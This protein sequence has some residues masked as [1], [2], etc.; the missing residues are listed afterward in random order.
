MPLPTVEI[1]GHIV[2]LRYTEFARIYTSRFNVVGLTGTMI[3]GDPQLRSAYND[4]STISW[5]VKAAGSYSIVAFSIAPNKMT[6]MRTK[7]V[8]DIVIN[9]DIE[10]TGASNVELFPDFTINLIT[11]SRKEMIDEAA[12]KLLVASAQLNAAVA[13]LNSMN[14]TKEEVL[15]AFSRAELKSMGFYGPTFPINWITIQPYP[16]FLGKMKNIA[17]ATG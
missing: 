6:P 17:Q 2:T 5:E 8:F 1:F 16:L 10:L 12:D 4:N 11:K 9:D 13:A 14:L 7:V 3:A 15:A